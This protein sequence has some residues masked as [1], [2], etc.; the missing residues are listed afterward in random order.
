MD[1]KEKHIIVLRDGTFV[2]DEIIGVVKAMQPAT[3]QTPETPYNQLILR[4]LQTPVYLPYD[5]EDE[6]D[7]EYEYIIEH[8]RFINV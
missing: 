8:I 7:K 3:L 1:K 5:T 6:R 4:A 2:A